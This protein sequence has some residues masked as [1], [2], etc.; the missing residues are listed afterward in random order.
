MLN[1]G[2][3]QIFGE[4]KPEKTIKKRTVISRPKTSSRVKHVISFGLL[5]VQSCGGAAFA[6]PTKS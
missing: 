1:F 4:R 5:G 2:H 3:G 6:D